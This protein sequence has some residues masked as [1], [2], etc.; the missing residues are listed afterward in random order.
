MP[1]PEKKAEEKEQDFISRCVKAIIDEYPQEQALAICY[2]KLS[3]DNK[4]S[5]KKSQEQIFI[6]KPNKNENRGDYVSRCAS[7][8]KMKEQYPDKKLRYAGCLTSFNEYYKYWA[9]LE[10]FESVDTIMESCMAEQ[11]SKGM[12]YKSAYQYCKEQQEE[13]D[14]VIEEPVLGESIGKFDEELFRTNLDICVAKKVKE[15]GI[16]RA[17]ARKECAASI[18]VNPVEKI[19]QGEKMTKAQ[20]F[21]QMKQFL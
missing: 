9:K 7:H 6:L 17:Q 1:I 10:E 5:K 15:T 3:K 4:M 11:K 21:Q 12:D 20:F 14:N 19:I 18:V 13:L 8:R 16:T 2:S